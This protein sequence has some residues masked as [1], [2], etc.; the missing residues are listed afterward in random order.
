MSQNI[1]A[2]FAIFTPDKLLRVWQIALILFATSGVWAK[3]NVKRADFVKSIKSNSIQTD[4]Y[5]SSTKNSK[6]P[7]PFA[8]RRFATIFIL[9]K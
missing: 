7:P 8:L 6:S 9:Q 5:D 1:S 3:D 2:I 4:F